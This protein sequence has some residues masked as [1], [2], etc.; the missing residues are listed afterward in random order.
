[1]VALRRGLLGQG[2]RA[3]DHIP[4]ALKTQACGTRLQIAHAA[5]VQAALALL[6]LAYHLHRHALGRARDG[7]TR[8]GRGNDIGHRGFRPHLRHHG[9]RHLPHRAKRGHFKCLRHA[10]ATRHCQLAQIIAQQ[11]HYHHILSAV[12]G[13][14]LQKCRPFGIVAI[15]QNRRRAFHRFGENVAIG[16][17]AQKQFGRKAQM[18]SRAAIHF[19]RHTRQHPIR[20]LLTLAQTRIQ[21]RGFAIRLARPRGGV[22]DLVNIAAGNRRVYGRYVRQILGLAD[23]A[24]Q[25]GDACGHRRSVLPRQGSIGVV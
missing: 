21:A 17:Y 12:F 24:V 1:M 22:I 4:S 5:C 7:A 6:Q 16:L 8:K 20:H 14:V 13:I 15:A 25:S 9:R 3:D 23:L 19:G 11:V 10:H 18:P 2:Q